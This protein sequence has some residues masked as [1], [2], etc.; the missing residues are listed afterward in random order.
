MRNMIVEAVYFWMVFN[1]T[2]KWNSYLTIGKWNKLVR[3]EKSLFFITIDI[4]Y[5][6]KLI[7]YD[8]CLMDVI[9]ILASD[10]FRPS[11][12]T[13]L[14]VNITDF[15]IWEQTYMYQNS[16]VQ[17]SEVQ[18]TKI[19]GLTKIMMTFVLDPWSKYDFRECSVNF[20]NISSCRKDWPWL[21]YNRNSFTAYIIMYTCH[22]MTLWPKHGGWEYGHSF[23]NSSFVYFLVLNVTLYCSS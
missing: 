16:K 22:T 13:T 12:Y 5:V 15:V 10:R 2:I 18:S 4:Y 6:S 14:A 19:H 17:L 8:T 9:D 21:L 7:L 11:S 20:L 1:N 3:H 23:W